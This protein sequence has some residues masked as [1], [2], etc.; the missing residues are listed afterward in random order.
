MKLSAVSVKYVSPRP[1]RKTQAT[2]KKK[3]SWLQKSK[4]VQNLANNSR[5]S[6]E[7]QL[8]MQYMHSRR[9]RENEGTFTPIHK[10]KLA[11]DKRNMVLDERSRD[12]TIHC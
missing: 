10:K 1:R 7:N 11:E 2:E 12:L 5:G 3:K 4:L 6:E 8:T 9:R